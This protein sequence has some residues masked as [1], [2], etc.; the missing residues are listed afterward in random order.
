MHPTHA[1]ALVYYFVFHAYYKTLPSNQKV[2]ST[3]QTRRQT[4]HNTTR[5]TRTL[6]RAHAHNTRT[7]RTR[8]HSLIPH[9]GSLTRQW[10]TFTLIGMCPSLLLIDHG[11][12][13]YNNIS[14]G[15][16]AHAVLFPASVCLGVH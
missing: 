6:T 15:L 16:G 8:T 7:T 1:L 5:N 2:Y 9:I 11:H 10:L 14:L 12:F 13:Q 4:I 3:P